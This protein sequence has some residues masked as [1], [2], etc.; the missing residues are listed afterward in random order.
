VPSVV[1]RTLIIGGFDGIGGYLR[2]YAEI[3]RTLLPSLNTGGA[4]VVIGILRLPVSAGVGKSV[5]A[6]LD[7]IP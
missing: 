1:A 5:I 3:V 2:I 4:E 6:M 7:R